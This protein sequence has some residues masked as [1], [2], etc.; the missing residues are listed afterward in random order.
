MHLLFDSAHRLPIVTITSTLAVVIVH[1][2]IT[3]SVDPAPPANGLIAVITNLEPALVLSIVVSQNSNTG[4]HISAAALLFAALLANCNFIN[5]LNTS[6]GS[7]SFFAVQSSA[8]AGAWI[9]IITL[10]LISLIGHLLGSVGS[11]GFGP[12]SSLADGNDECDSDFAQL[13]C[14]CC[15]CCH[16]PV[17]RVPNAREMQGYAEMGN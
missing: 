12:C 11:F 3:F 17:S 10:C 6:G 9:V 4:L 1:F 5:N 14:S 2:L 7:S 15:P 16:R 8:Q 13:L